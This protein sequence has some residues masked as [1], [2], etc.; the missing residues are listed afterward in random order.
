MS[1]TDTLQQNGKGFAVHVAISM[2][3]IA[4]GVAGSVYMIV[5]E[6]DP[7]ALPLLLFAAGVAWFILARRRLKR[8]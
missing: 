2:L 7:P 6:D 8:R 4:L 1:A 3:L 5:V